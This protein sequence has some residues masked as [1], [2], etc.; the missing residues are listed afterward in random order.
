MLKESFEFDILDP[1]K[2]CAI[3]STHLPKSGSADSAILYS[4]LLRS[5]KLLLSSHSDAFTATQAELKL[6]EVFTAKGLSFLQSS[7]SG[8]N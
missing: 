1:G 6:C 2:V 7:L 8:S 3:V 5:I 4:S